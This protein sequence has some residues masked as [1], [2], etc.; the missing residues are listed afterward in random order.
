MKK[1]LL[2]SIALTFIAISCKKEMKVE[3]KEMPLKPY[4]PAEVENAVIYEVNIRQYSAEGS[5]Q[6]FIKDIPQL[7]NLG[8]KV[9]WV[10]PIQPISMVK[11]K[12]TGDKSIEDFTDPEE[13]KKYLGSYYAIADYSSVNPDYGTL[14]DFKELVE[15]AH[16][17]GMYVILDWVANHTGWDHKWITEHPEFYHKNSKGEITDPLNPETGEPWGWTDVA[18]LNYEEKSLFE[19]MA[20]QMLYWIREADIDGFRC[21]VADNVK[22]EYWEYVYP[23]LKAE[24][25][26]FM[27]AESNKAELLASV[28]DMGYNWELHHLMNE[29]AQGKK[30]VKDF[31]FLMQKQDSIY[32]PEMILMNFTSNHDE[33]AWQGSEY[34]RLGNAVETFAALTYMLPGMPLIYNGQEYDFNRKLKFFEK[35]SIWHTKGKMFPIYEKLG[36]LKNEN[37]ALNGGVKK[38]TYKRIHTSNDTQ[39]LAFEREKEGKKVYFIANLSKLPQKVKVPLKG[40]FQ[41]YMKSINI[42]VSS[43]QEM[44]LQPWEYSILIPH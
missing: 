16:E 12:A 27:L 23:K 9:L 38:A 11:R 30:N 28:F 37:P 34:E 39:I 29:I 14:E 15:I 3:V 44:N 6:A 10:M 13:R 5:I 42:H 35:D 7:K 32:K 4:S 1:F 36:K 8:V 2:Y 40:S 17:N 20:E 22:L 24:K 33:N 21:D 41:D 19:A 31:D 25:P 43:D 18:H 26:V